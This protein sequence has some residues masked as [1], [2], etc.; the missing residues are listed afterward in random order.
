MARKSEKALFGRKFTIKLSEDA[1]WLKKCLNVC[2]LPRS[3]TTIICELLKLEQNVE[4]PEQLETKN[5]I[6]C[7]S[8]Q[9]K[10]RRMT[11][12]LRFLRSRAMC[13]EHHADMCKDCFENK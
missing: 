7:A 5:R 8:C 4:P 11:H 13:G 3:T 12:K 1:P 6:I 10:L 9:C 2:T